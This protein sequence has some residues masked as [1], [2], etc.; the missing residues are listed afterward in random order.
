MVLS[1]ERLPR[2]R[3]RRYTERIGTAMIK[4][5]LLLAWIACAS[6][7]Q[8]QVQEFVLDNGMKLLMVPRKGSPNVNAEPSR[9]A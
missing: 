2:P 6:A 8:V 4:P 1:V 7:Q 5:P 9:L 3:Q